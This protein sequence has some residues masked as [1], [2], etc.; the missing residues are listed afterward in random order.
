MAERM[1]DPEANAP[2]EDID[3]VLKTV[4]RAVLDEAAA[5]MEG[6]EEVVPFTGL[7]VKEN[8]FIETHPGDDVEECFLAARHEVEGARGATAYAFCYDG[9]IET[10][11]GMRDALIAEGGLPGEEQAYAFG[12]LYDDNDIN[13]EITYIGPAPNFMENL[14]L[15]LDMEGSLDPMADLSANQ[16]DQVDEAQVEAIADKLEKAAE[17]AEKAQVEK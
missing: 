14:K 6:G 17:E 10:E 7:A 9:Y 1:V 16:E 8:L 13:K 11:D 15:E 4:I 12:Y 3:D 2:E 5:K